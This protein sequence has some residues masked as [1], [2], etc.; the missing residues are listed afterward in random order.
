MFWRMRAHLIWTRPFTLY[1]IGPLFPMFVIMAIK[2]LKKSCFCAFDRTFCIV[3]SDENKKQMVLF[4]F[5]NLKF[6]RTT[7][8]TFR[9]P[10]II[11]DWLHAVRAVTH[12]STS[13]KWN[14][15]KNTIICVVFGFIDISLHN[16]HFYN[17]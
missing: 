5:K 10:S 14:Q 1:I 11:R 13:D 17:S 2:N 4:L 3:G 8:S 9:T 15:K 6:L 7:V 16:Y 12:N